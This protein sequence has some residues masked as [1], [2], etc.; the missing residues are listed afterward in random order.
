MSTRG[1]YGFRKDGRDKT[2]YNHF[3]SYPACLG[4]KVLEFCRDTNITEMHRIFDM[5]KMVRYP[6]KPTG[7]Q[8]EECAPYTNLEVSEQSTDDWYCLLQKAQGK[9][10]IHKSGFPYMYCS[11][12]LIKHS[13]W[14]EYGYIINLDDSSLEFWKGLQ[15]QAQPGNRYGAMPDGDYYPCRLALTFPLDGI[16]ENAVDLMK[17]VKTNPEEV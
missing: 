16:P 1:I 15:R 2:G 12:R 11:G 3:D 13:R 17:A 9:L 6:E 5:I 8:I 7:A 4:A 10:E 14:C